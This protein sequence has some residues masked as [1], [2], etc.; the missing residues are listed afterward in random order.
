MIAINDL[1]TSAANVSGGSYYCFPRLPWGGR[2]PYRK[3]RGLYHLPVASNTEFF[4]NTTS[5]FSLAVN[6]T[7]SQQIGFKQT[8]IP[9]L[10][11]V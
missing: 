3:K 4:A 7:H 6:K 2:Y 8:I 5:S 10:G 1:V 11:V 9:T